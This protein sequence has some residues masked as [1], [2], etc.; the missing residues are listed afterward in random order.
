MSDPHVVIF[1][2]LADCYITPKERA[3][4]R[5]CH[6]LRRFIFKIVE[7]R[8]KE[9]KENPNSKDCGDFLGILL[10]DDNFQGDNEMIVDEC[11]TFFFAGSQTSSVAA[12]N[13]ILMLI[14]HPE[15]KDKIL[16][17]L[18]TVIIQPHLI[19]LVKQGKLQPGETIKLNVLDLIN[20]ENQ[21]YLDFYTNCHNESLRMQPPVYF[22][23]SIMMM[24]DCQCDY[25][26][27]RK[28][29][30]LSIDIFRLHNNPDEW[31][32]PTEFIPERFDSKNPF[33]LTPLGKPRNPFSFA[34]FL[35]GQR[36]CI[37]K[38]FIETIS[39]LTVPTLISN[40]DMQF[41][42]G[43]DSDTFMLPHNNMLCTF[44]PRNDIV[45][46]QKKQEYKHK[47]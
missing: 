9:I 20:F 23:S 18:D 12:Q 34:P 22:S 17:E 13:L 1:P 24:K 19:D 26:N 25:L 7:S 14:K 5:N 4:Q 44:I 39:K 33:Y 46:T 41:L 15:I 42:K 35:G 28:G 10:K 45:I 29:D 11:L 37:G 27:I 2:F 16:K 38:T 21:G 30:V 47:I 8:R 36:I 31:Q 6:R 3:I 40:F 43:V 32:S